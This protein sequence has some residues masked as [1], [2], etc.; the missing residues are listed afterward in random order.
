MGWKASFA[1]PAF[2]PP[3]SVIWTS[4]AKS[5][6]HEAVMRLLCGGDQRWPVELPHLG[7]K[8]DAQ[9][10]ISR[11]TNRSSR[12]T[13][14]STNPAQCGQIATQVGSV[15]PCRRKSIDLIQVDP[16]A[17]MILN[18]IDCFRR[19]WFSQGA[20]SEL[21]D[22]SQLCK[23]EPKGGGNRTRVLF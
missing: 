23:M 11:R 10:V 19:R 9:L 18:R 5:T 2:W 7:Q 16:G 14:S 20:G 17:C 15:S 12:S 21:Y 8:F 4:I 22:E 6:S 13:R 1:H 3:A